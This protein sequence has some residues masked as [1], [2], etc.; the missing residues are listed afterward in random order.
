MKSIINQVP[1]SMFLRP[2][3]H[4]YQGHPELYSPQPT[5]FPENHSS[6][7]HWLPHL[8]STQTLSKRGFQIT[9]I[10]YLL[11]S[12][13]LLI[14]SFDVL[15]SLVKM[16][17]TVLAFLGINRK[18]NVLMGIFTGILV[19]DLVDWP[20]LMGVTDQLWSEG[21]LRST[22]S[23]WLVFL[24]FIIQQTLLVL[25]IVHQ[26][27]SRQSHHEQMELQTGRMCS[28]VFNLNLTHHPSQQ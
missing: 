22:Y 26:P 8:L 20:I 13:F 16:A 21:T 25:S 3:T 5:T 14:F 4:Y 27:N 7:C 24:V 28:T 10:I 18:D 12:S 17:A 6:C 11:L 1:S 19:Y 9:L 2:P 23:V 15:G